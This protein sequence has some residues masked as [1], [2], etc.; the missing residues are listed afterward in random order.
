MI[1]YSK[2]YHFKPENDNSSENETAAQTEQSAK[3]ERRI[4]TKWNALILLVISAICMI[5][6]VSNV[7]EV[8]SLLR[9]TN[10]LKKQAEMIE[11]KNQLLMT[12]INELESPE[13]ITKIAREK[14]GMI[15]AEQTPVKI[16]RK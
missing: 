2:I 14:F 7:I 16:G 3:K 12:K 1:D 6:Y 5:T 15:K 11:D 4:F 9:E 8:K 10:E 13:R